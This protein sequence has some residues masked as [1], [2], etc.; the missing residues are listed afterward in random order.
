MDERSSVI[1]EFPQL[2]AQAREREMAGKYLRTI[3]LSVLLCIVPGANGYQLIQDIPYESPG[4]TRNVLDVIMP[5]SGPAPGLPTLVYVHGGAWHTRDKA[6]DLPVYIELTNHGYAV[7]A[8]NYTLAGPGFPSFPQAVQDVKNAVRWVRMSGAQYGLSPIIVVIG[9][10]AGGHLAAMAALTSGMP[11]FET[12]QAP[13]GG[14]RPEAFISFA[15]FSDLEW[16]VL[17]HGQQAMFQRFLGEWYDAQ[18]APLYRSASPIFHITA[19]DPPGGFIHGTADPVVPHQHA[20]MIADALQGA[21]I[22]TSVSLVQ[23]A[24][25]SFEPFGGPVGVAQRLVTMLAALRP[26]MVTPDLDGNG[27]LNVDDF[28]TFIDLFIA[29]DPR[30]DINR[31][32]TLNIDDFLAY[33]SLF[34]Q[35]C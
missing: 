26:H 33:I 8:C 4:S 18:T 32:G 15:G 13:V 29:E 6:D 14:Y 10:S 24:W 17:T 35:G 11:E 25:H 34:V 31:D 21:G 9:P 1:R 28:L 20:L 27:V 22:F 3:I 16:H 12:L 19:C 2:A 5:S 23:G 30:A 7:V